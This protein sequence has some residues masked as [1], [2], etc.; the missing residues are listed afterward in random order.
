MP[1]IWE[2]P[3]TFFLSLSF[4]TNSSENSLNSTFKLYLNPATFHFQTL[5]PATIKSP[6]GS[7]SSF[8][9]ISM[10]IP[11]PAAVYSLH[12]PRNPL[13][14]WGISY[15]SYSTPCAGSLFYWEK[16]SSLFC[17]PLHPLWSSPV[18]SLTL[19]SRALPRAHP[20][21]ATLASAL[22]RIC[23]LCSHVRQGICTPGCLCLKFSSL[24]SQNG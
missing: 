6:V 16:N 17:G 12:N 9:R 13:T 23:Q 4:H 18:T 11:F 20:A 24:T 10:L 2:S 22:P 3:L 15:H 5:V 1:N 14:T 7:Y 8:S 19:L 21:P